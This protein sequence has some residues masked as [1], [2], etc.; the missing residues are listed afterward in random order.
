[1]RPTLEKPPAG[2][3]RPPIDSVHPVYAHQAAIEGFQIFAEALP[4]IIW[5]ADARGKLEWYN[6]EFHQYTGLTPRTAAGWRWLASVHEDDREAM[7]QQWAHALANGTLLNTILRLRSTEGMYRWFS[8]SA[9]PFRSD[10]GAVMKWFGTLTDIHERQVAL[11][12]N[13][14]VVDALMKGF[15]AKELPI[16]K[17]LKIDTLY[18]AA[19]ALERLG[20][21]WFDIFALPDGRIGFSLGDVCGHGVDAAVKMGEA[22]QAI[23][24]A[25]CLDDPAPERVLYQAN[26]VLFLNDHHVSITTAVYGLIDTKLR[27][28]TYAAAGHH[29]PILVRSNGEAIVLPNHGFP[30]GVENPLPPHIKT[31]SFTFEP[32]AMM[33]L[34]TDGLIEIGHDIFDGERR[35]LAAC[36][37]AMHSKSAHPASSVANHV[38]GEME[39]SD[40]IAILTF[41]FE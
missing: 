27:T 34:Y 19:N 1:M 21:D 9:R 6:Q 36:T 38:L 20:G 22:K 13:A 30:L 35:L 26:T 11:E 32:G 15:L 41:S 18:R 14:H 29:A 10:D 25:A 39:P 31:H 2:P 33:V 40:D 28:V 4:C 12:A 16:T 5:L 17:G 3:F 24:V 8:I 23:F 37:E 7:T